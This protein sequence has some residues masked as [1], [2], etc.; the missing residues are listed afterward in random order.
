MSIRVV[1]PKQGERLWHFG[2]SGE[3]ADERQGP[4]QRDFSEPF[5]SR[6]LSNFEAVDRCN[7]FSYI[8]FSNL[9]S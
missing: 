7:I 8:F 4:K 1:G 2:S 6:F 3:A 5:L 9:S